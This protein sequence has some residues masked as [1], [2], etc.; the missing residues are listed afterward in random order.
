MRG[1]SGKAPVAAMIVVA[2][3]VI[4]IMAGILMLPKPTEP[5]LDQPPSAPMNV[6]A[7]PGD[8]VVTLSWQPPADNGTSAVQKYR[9]YRGTGAGAL[10]MIRELGTLLSY[11]D[12]GLTNGQAYS[13][14]VSAVNSVGEGTRSTPVAATPGAAAGVPSEPRNLAA[15]PGNTQV[16]LTW[17]PP[18]NTSGAPITAYRIFR[19]NASGS[20]AFF[21]ET[22]SAT[23]YTCTGLTNGQTYYFQVSAR[24]LAGEGPRSAEAS[25]TPAGGPTVPSEP[26]NL[27]YVPGA[28]NVTLNWEPPASDGGSMITGYSV[29]RGTAPGTLLLLA[30]IENLTTYIDAGLLPDVTFYYQVSARNALGNG[31]RTPELSAMPLSKPTQPLGLSAVAGLGSVSLSWS[32]PARTG[33]SPILHYILYRG[34]AAGGESFLVMLDT[35]LAHVDSGLVNGTTYYYQVSASNAQGEGAR[36]VE[37]SATPQASFDKPSAPRDLV[38]TGGDAK[39]DLSWSAPA[40]E[41]GAPVSKYTVYRNGTLL[42]ELGVVTLHTDAGLDNGGTYSYEVSAS[43]SLGEGPRSLAAAATPAALPGAPTALSAVPSNHNVSLSWQAPASDGGA[44]VTGYAVFRDGAPLVSSGTETTYRDGTVTNGQTYTYKVAA[45]NRVGQGPFSNEAT[46]T[47]DLRPV[48]FSAGGTGTDAGADIGT[49]SLANIYVTGYFT[50]TVD[51]DPGSGVHELTSAGD[52]DIFVAKYD[53]DGNY[54]W[55]F[56]VG[57]NGADCARAIRVEGDGTVWI[58]GWFSLVAD[59]DP[60]AG[61]AA[62]ASFGDTDSFAARYSSD[63]SYSWAAGWGGSGKDVALDISADSD[64]NSYITGHFEGTVDFDTGAGTAPS[65]SRGSFD[66]FVLSL[67]PGGAYRW[68]L[69]LGSV[70]TDSGMAIQAYANGTF[71]LSGYFNESVDFDAGPDTNL[72]NSS[73]YTDVFLARYN[74]SGGFL[75]AGAIGGP[76]NE[77]PAVGGL[78]FDGPGN[79]YLTGSFTGLCDFQPTNMSA[80]VP[81]NGANDAFIAEYDPTGEYRWAYGAGGTGDDYGERVAVDDSGNIYWTGRFT[82]TQVDFDLT[83][84]TKYL[85]AFG[86][87]GAS[88]IFLAKYMPGGILVWAYNFGAPVSGPML[89]SGWSICV[90]VNGNIVTTGQFYG[91]VDFDPTAGT[92]TLTSAGDAD[93]FVV[94]LDEDGKPA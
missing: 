28:S 48:A 18:A 79:V 9:V 85:D 16:A 41:G 14:R 47:P 3:V 83:L 42:V 10:S 27:T 51:F 15:R 40:N 64:G 57:G 87:G 59:F 12:G 89:S 34:T 26:R 4:V 90:D 19:G 54:L 74:S 35:V 11:I 6:Q 69:T 86:T 76:E 2:V 45:Q 77:T 60:G 91:S 65:T 24:N 31:A 62:L 17:D 20:E 88:D 80:N 52:T 55:A 58:A 71:W 21:T 94:R 23:G 61:T 37:A 70:Q 72:T 66:A 39:V 93:I 46:A 43:N 5:R 33:G 44:P 92:K 32:P 13:Y 67:G 73:G 25:A 75:W 68:H 38:A 84:D 36:S 50:G 63:G 1:R 81:S 8:Q 29:Y 56:R 7:A 82:G 53:V 22:G 30:P 78:T 49:D